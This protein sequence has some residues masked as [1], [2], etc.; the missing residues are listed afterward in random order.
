MGLRITYLHRLPVTHSYSVQEALDRP[1]H[2]V[3]IFLDLSK[4]YDIINRNML[5]DKVDSYGVR[6]SANM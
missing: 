2:V 5:L 1:P 6:S 4:A 3:G